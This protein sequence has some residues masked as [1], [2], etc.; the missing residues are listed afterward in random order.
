VQPILQERRSRRSRQPQTAL[1][2]QLEHAMDQGRLEALVLAD[3]DGL[4]LAHAGDYATCRE[5]AAVAP[6]LARSSLSMQ[7]P[8]VDASFRTGDLTVRPLEVH[9]QLLVLASLGGGSARGAVLDHVRRGV[10]RILTSH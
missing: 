6:L 7:L 10:E 2:Y 8:L 9:G 5:A 4:M 3:G 1:L